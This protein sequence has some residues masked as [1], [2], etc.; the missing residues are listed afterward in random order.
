MYI[1]TVKHICQRDFKMS[2]FYT[3]QAD[4]GFGLQTLGDSEGYVVGFEKFDDA[5][6]NM[7]AAI[8]DDGAIRSCVWEFDATQGT[9][10]IVIAMIFA[11]IDA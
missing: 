2:K 5:Q 1:K 10:P 11:G 9:K 6:K 3:V 4:F 7:I 8:V